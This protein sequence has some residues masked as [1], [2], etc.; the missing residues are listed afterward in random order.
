MARQRCCTSLWRWGPP[1]WAE[2]SGYISGR[3]NIGTQ[4]SSPSA[5]TTT[6]SSLTDPGSL[7]ISLASLLSRI[8]FFS[9]SDFTPCAL[10]FSSSQGYVRKKQQGRGSQCTAESKLT[11]AQ[12]PRASLSPHREVSP[13]LFSQP[14]QRPSASASDLVLFGGSDEELNDD[15][16]S[17]AASDAVELSGSIADP[18]LLP[19]S[20]PSAAKAGLD[21]KLLR[22]L[23][24]AV[25][26]LGLEWSPP[27]EP[28][29]SRGSVRPLVSDPRRSFLKF[30]TGSRDHGAPPLLRSPPYLRL[31]HPHRG[32]R[33][34]RKGLLEDTPSR[35]PSLM[36][37]FPP[38]AYLDRRSKGLLNASLRH[39]VVPGHATLPAQALQ[40]R[41]CFQSP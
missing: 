16:M 38:A 12:S 19:S 1:E 21:A 32:Q 11:S 35:F 30:T 3:F 8:A 37:R 7:K 2:P 33:R 13:V 26:E 20:A 17:L 18:A 25:E 4:M 14:D 9:E 6:T 28:S 31:I 41:S 24:K 15:S 40:L 29:R 23:L 5:T 22:I 27:E 36:P 34:W 10:L 39:K